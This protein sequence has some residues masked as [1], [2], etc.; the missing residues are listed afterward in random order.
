MFIFWRSSAD[1][2]PLYLA[3]IAFI[4][5]WI[6]CICFMLFIWKKRMGNRARVMKKVRITMHQPQLLTYW[7]SQRRA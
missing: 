3:W 2:E 1:L 6:L 7:L 4:C 5:G